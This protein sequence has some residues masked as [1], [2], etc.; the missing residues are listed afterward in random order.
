MIVLL[1]NLIYF[2]I[3]LIIS[4]HKKKKLQRSLSRKGSQRLGDRKVNNNATLYD[5]DI[6]PAICS[7]KGTIALAKTQ[8]HS[9]YNLF[10]CPFY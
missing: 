10:F 9:S 5:K 6:A 7:P 4:T 1:L 8:F 2:N 3:L